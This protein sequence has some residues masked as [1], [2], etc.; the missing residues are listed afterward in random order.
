[1]QAEEYDLSLRLLDGGW[2]INRF[3]DIAVWHMKT[4]DARVPTRT[5]RLDTR[6]N[7]LLITRHF[8]RKWVLP[9]AIDWMRRYRWIAQGKGRQHQLAFCRGLAQG[10]VR[11]MYPG[12]RKPVSDHA[13]EQFS[14]IDEIERRMRQVVT[15][16]GHR[17]ILLLDVGKNILPYR[18]AA[19]KIGARIV[20][21]ADNHLAKANRNYRGVPVVTDEAAQ[22][23]SFD[24]AIVANVSPVHAA[25]RLSHWRRTSRKPAIDLFEPIQTLALVA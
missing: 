21:I 24:V 7:L 12:H 22:A 3:R 13:F 16:G 15:S 23:M 18:L 6:N 9:F 5:T 2:E 20:A 14:R 19:A 1:M 17:T 4:P 10:V 25:N 11:S 8:P